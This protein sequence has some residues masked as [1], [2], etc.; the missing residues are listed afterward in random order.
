[1]EDRQNRGITNVSNFT[2][3]PPHQQA[4]RA[5]C[6]HPSGVFAEFRKEEIEQSIP[7]RFEQIVREHPD[8]I[9]V[10][11]KNYELTYEQ[12]NKLANRVARTVLAHSGKGQGQ[13]ALLLEHDA[14]VVAA[15]IGVLKAG[16][17]Y[18][19]LD[20]SYPRERLDYMLEDSEASLLLTD[21]V[22][23]SMADALSQNVP[24]IDIE[25]LG[26]TLPD[27][28]LALRRSPESLAFILYTSGST[29]APKG[30]SQTH[31]NVLLDTKNYTNAG[32]YCPHDR[33]LLVV[34][35]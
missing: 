18:V 7:S 12:L 16:K 3:P 23:R 13:V 2:E 11:T 14:P 24:L 32:H 17:I 20:A 35:V 19:P 21:Q 1:M 30:F 33:L 6:F 31:R 28:N 9:A 29:G 26:S 22:N 5:K 10:K 8:R 15:M 27:E 34:P 4:I 25:G